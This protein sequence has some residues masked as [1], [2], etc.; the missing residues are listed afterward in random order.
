MIRKSIIIMLMLMAVISV[1]LMVLS[2]VP[3]RNLRIYETNSLSITGWKEVWSAQLKL[4]KFQENSLSLVCSR[5][6]ITLVYSHIIDSYDMYYMNYKFSGFWINKK[7][8]R[9]MDSTVANAFIPP[10]NEQERINLLNPR[11]TTILRFPSWFPPVLFGFYPVLAF[12]RG[13]I[14]RWR[15]YRKGLCSNCGYNLTGN[16]SGICPECGEAR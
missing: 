2:Y 13:P 14:R 6:R 15:R 5:G 9:G 12:F 3:T 4:G 1:T 8:G 16:T 11:S 7:I 10:L